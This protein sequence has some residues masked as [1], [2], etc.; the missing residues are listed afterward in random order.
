MVVQERERIL[1]T[2]PEGAARLSIGRSTLYELIRT[3][4]IPTVRFGSSVRV[5]VADLQA[6]A[7]RQR[8]EPV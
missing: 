3:G 4:A 7:L 5:R 2:I 8:S 6:W 1:V